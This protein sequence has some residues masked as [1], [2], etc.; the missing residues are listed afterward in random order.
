MLASSLVLLGCGSTADSAKNS[1][2]I[3]GT[4][5]APNVENIKGHM[6]FLAHDLLEGRDTGSRGHEI[7]SLYIQTEFQRYGLKGAGDDDTFMQRVLF[8][9]G[10]LVQESP[11]LVLTDADG[12]TSE[13]KFP[14]HFISG[15][16]LSTVDTSV[17]APV[18]FVGYGIVAQKLDHDDYKGL[19]VEGKIVVALSGRPSSFP[20]DV[21]SHVASRTQKS[22]YAADRGAV[23]FITIQTPAAEARRPYDRSIN[24]VRS[25]RMAWIGEDG[26]PGNM[27]K[28]LKARAFLKT[29]PALMLLVC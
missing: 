10:L 22:N 21:G 18:V 17:S 8:R 1:N 24:F 5:V 14:K 4:V 23:G 11:S 27:R 13:L 25:P 16:D 26:I 15:P 3:N 20:S 12:N 7:A 2:D 6:N 28:E 29:S 19:D 9:R